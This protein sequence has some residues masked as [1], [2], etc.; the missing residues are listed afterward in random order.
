MGRGEEGGFRSCAREPSCFLAASSMQQLQ[1][2]N[3]CANEEAEKK[4]DNY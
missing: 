2:K 1:L 4:K 3:S